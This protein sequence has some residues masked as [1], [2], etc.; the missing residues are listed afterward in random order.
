MRLLALLALLA[1][2]ARSPAR[3]EGVVSLLP[4]FTEIL[5]ALGEERRLV[6]C[7]AYCKPGREVVRLP[8]QDAAAAEAILRVGP[9]VVLKQA[10]RTPEDPLKA[11]L[12][13]AHVRVLSLPSET[14]AD[15]RA[16]ILA[17]GAEFGRSA[18]AAAYLA[19]F[20]ADLDAARAV[21]AGRASPSVLFVTRRSAGAVAN[22]DAA[23]PGTFLDEL[24]RAA[25]GR[26]ALADLD[27]PYPTITLETF[28]R[29]APEV[30][31]DNLPAEGDPLGAWR[32]FAG[33]VP[34]VRDGRVFAVR[35]A[36]L[37]IPGP[38]LPEAVRRLAEMIHGRP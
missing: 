35:D 2:C 11:A 15:V 30:I 10:P 7:T 20:D 26:N 16:A 34:A 3:G 14:I 33:Q 22:I 36:A 21:S 13:R 29:R 12:E 18:D 17:I 6:G 9:S 5:V 23:G 32:K 37:L 1:A 19:R 24:I 4:S 27:A 8:W 28:V 31:I 38:R 25:G